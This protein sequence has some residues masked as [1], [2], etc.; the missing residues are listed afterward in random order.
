MFLHY[1]PIWLRMF[2]PGFI[3]RM[4]TREKKLYLTFDDG[5]IPDITEGVLDTLAAYQA[6]ATFFC[7]GDNV[8]KH[9]RI[10]TQVLD[11]GHAIGNHTFNHMNGW[12]TEDELYLDNVLACDEMLDVETQLFRPP[13]GRIRKSQSAQLLPTRKIIMWDVLSGDFS[14]KITPDVCLAKTIRYARP[15]S[16][17]LFHDSIKAAAN[18]QYALPRM[19]EH[20]AAKGYAFEALPMTGAEPFHH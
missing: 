3:W 17:I 7:I 8:R 10:F 19:L 11:A 5:P 9:P 13:Y 14:Q 15:G 6:K 12:K 20:F 1:S 4:P 2:F 16:I 18:M